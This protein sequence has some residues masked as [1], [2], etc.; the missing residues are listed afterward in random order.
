MG[1]EQKRFQ[2][3]PD[4][5]DSVLFL[6]YARNEV[7]RVDVPATQILKRNEWIDLVLATKRFST[8]SAFCSS[9][10]SCAEFQRWHYCASC[11]WRQVLLIG[12][13]TLGG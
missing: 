10:E 3:F 7:T 4:H 6:D 8:D 5:D 1:G 13:G 11:S 9:A 2:N 12:A